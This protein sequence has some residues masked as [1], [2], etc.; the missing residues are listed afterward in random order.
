[1][2]D[3][4][5]IK[6]KCTGSTTV[7][8]SLGKEDRKN[9]PSDHQSTGFSPLKKKPNNGTDDVPDSVVKAIAE[10]TEIKLEEGD[11]SDEPEIC[12][13]CGS[14][15]CEWEEYKH[16]VLEEFHLMASMGS[17]CGL[18]QNERR[19]KLYRA[20]T[21]AKFDFLGAGIR[22]AIPPCCIEKIRKLCPNEG[23]QPYMGHYDG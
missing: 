3:E 9:R 19:K 23:S 14:S 18:M 15:P 7:S 12:H 11:L 1:M 8:V 10:V 20:F 21:L 4:Y 2:A 22:K 6:I 17:D 5:G 13:R 16:K